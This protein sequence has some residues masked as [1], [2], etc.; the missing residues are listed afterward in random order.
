ME[1][2]QI[3]QDI[4]DKINQEQEALDKKLKK[5]GPLTKEEMIIIFKVFN[6]LYDCFDAQSFGV[7][8]ATYNRIIDRVHALIV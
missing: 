8:K 5:L 3:S 7:D 2:V 1:V 4:I 6:N